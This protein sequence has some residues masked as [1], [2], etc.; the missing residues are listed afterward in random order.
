MRANMESGFEQQVRDR[1]ARSESVVEREL[2][3][4]LQL[5][6]MSAEAA[7]RLRRFQRK[8]DVAHKVFAAYD[9]RIEKA[10]DARLI[11]SDGYL[12]LALVCLAQARAEACLDEASRARLFTWVNSAFNALDHIA[13]SPEMLLQEL[14]RQCTRGLRS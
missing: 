12:G 9:E 3:D 14:E 10:T 1:L 13:D 8:I 7:W 5:E 11:T 4:W 2:A 6:V